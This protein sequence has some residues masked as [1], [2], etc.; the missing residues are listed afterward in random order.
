MIDDDANANDRHIVLD[1]NILVS[2]LLT[3][4]GNPNTILQAILDGKV[5][6]V[7]SAAIMAEYRSVLNRP[8]FAFDARDV[9][10]LLAFVEAFGDLADPDPSDAFMPDEA[11]R[12]FY[13]VARES[14]AVLA[15]GNEKHY[16]RFDGLMTPAGFIL[17]RRR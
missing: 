14:G 5:T 6:I 3:P 11:D 10:D 13:D 9:A 8:R 7:Y 12:P 4:L 16:P 17:A 1:T 2:A 15:T